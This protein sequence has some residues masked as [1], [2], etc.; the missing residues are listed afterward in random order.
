MRAG[1]LAVAATLLVLL[2]A[3]GAPAQ[4][5]ACAK[6]DFEVV[7]NEA[8]SVLRDLNRQN[9]PLFQAKLRQLKD[10]RS[11]SNDQFLKEAEPFVR[12]EQIVGYDQKSEELL[13]RITGGSLTGTSE[14]APDCSVLAE[15]RAAMIQ[16]VDTQKAKWTYMFSKIEK[17][18]TR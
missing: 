1:V 8:G 10:K 13:G 7:V 14:A 11:W 16:L 5:P 6:G 3:D 17:E 9:T 15:L 4:A 18:L 12:D 2:F